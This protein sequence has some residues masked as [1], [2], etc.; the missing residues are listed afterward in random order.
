MH[1]SLYTYNSPIAY[2][3]MYWYNFRPRSAYS[4]P[5]TKLTA[6]VSTTSFVG[7][8]SMQVSYHDDL[9]HHQNREINNVVQD[10]IFNWCI[11]KFYNSII[12]YQTPHTTGHPQSFWLATQK[13]RKLG[14]LTVCSEKYF[15]ST[16]EMRTDMIASS[17]QANTMH[18]T[19]QRW[20]LL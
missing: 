10:F 12:R 19:S 17:H 14:E 15:I 16:T 5:P 4:F 13:S 20:L 8:L 11:S 9:F 3:Y 6:V 18:V 2:Q 7:H 1:I